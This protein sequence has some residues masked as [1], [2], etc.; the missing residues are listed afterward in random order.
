MHI[1]EGF[2]PAAHCVAWYAIATPF[3]VHGASVK[4]DA[5]LKTEAERYT[6]R[7]AS[8]LPTKTEA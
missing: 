3:V 1:A 6:A 2:L 5:A 8:L 4:D 7:I